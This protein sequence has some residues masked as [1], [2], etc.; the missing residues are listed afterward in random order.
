MFISIILDQNFNN[1]NIQ[2]ILI[3]Y[4]CALN[5]YVTIQN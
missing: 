1:S 5:I 4:L 3:N 2:K